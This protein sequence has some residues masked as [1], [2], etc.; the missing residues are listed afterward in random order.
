M[1]DG[2]HV[3]ILL[4]PVVRLKQEGDLN[5]LTWSKHIIFL[6]LKVMGACGPG[7]IM[8]AVLEKPVGCRA[9]LVIRLFPMFSG[10]ADDK[11]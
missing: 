10:G 2:V 6:E 7:E 11:M 9:I 4:T 3:S 5:S 8:D 1:F